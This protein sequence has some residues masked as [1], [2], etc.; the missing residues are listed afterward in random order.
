LY[1]K[2]IIERMSRVFK[3]RAW[4]PQMASEELFKAEAEAAAITLLPPEVL[5]HICRQLASI[6]DIRSVR[7]AAK[8]LVAPAGA[9][10]KRLQS[11]DGH[12]P[13]ALRLGSLPRGHGPGGHTVRG[14]Q[15]RRGGEHQPIR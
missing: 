12:P 15:R 9:A 10:V 5:L 1:S 13:S 6:K 4:C 11:P 7:Q 3:R 8:A 2:S 14:Q